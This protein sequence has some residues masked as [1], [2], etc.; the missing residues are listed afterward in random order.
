MTNTGNT[1]LDT[2]IESKLLEIVKLSDDH[3]GDDDDDYNDC[4]LVEINISSSRPKWVSDQIKRGNNIDD[5]ANCISVLR[6]K[7]KIHSL[8]A[9]QI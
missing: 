5:N 4:Y 1:C 8:I 3:Y 6:R 2:M 9:I 7:D